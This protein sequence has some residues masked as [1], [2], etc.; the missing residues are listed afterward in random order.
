VYGAVQHPGTS[1]PARAA[2]SGVLWPL[3][4]GLC[5]AFGH[6]LQG[7]HCSLPAEQLWFDASIIKTT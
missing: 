2:M 5:R 1:I 7:F 6:G 4:L 3:E